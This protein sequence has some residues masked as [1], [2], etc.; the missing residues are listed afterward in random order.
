MIE[1]IKNV[2]S[3]DLNQQ[4]KIQRELFMERAVHQIGRLFKELGK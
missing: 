2:V 3:K 1:I 4:F